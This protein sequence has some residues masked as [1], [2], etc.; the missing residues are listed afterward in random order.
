MVENSF[1]HSNEHIQVD[2]DK[3]NKLISIN[4]KNKKGI[5]LFKGGNL[6]NWKIE[7]NAMNLKKDFNNDLINQFNLTGCLNLYNLN[8]NKVSFNIKNSSCEDAINLVNTNGNIDEIFV[9]NSISDAVD[10]DFSNLNIKI[11]ID[12]SFNDCLDLSVW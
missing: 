1:F 8:L 5:A 10:M 9:E 3:L 6:N 4:Q 12:N 7:F 11:L 2:V